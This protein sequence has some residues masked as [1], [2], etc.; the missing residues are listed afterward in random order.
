MIDLLSRQAVEAELVQRWPQRKQDLVSQL[1]ERQHRAAI[2]QR[3]SSFHPADVAFVLESL[4]KDPRDLA[5]SL[6]PQER[7]GA[8]LLETSDAA[9]CEGSSRSGPGTARY[10]APCSDS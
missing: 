3:L 8:V 6:V 7:R 9:C 10:G 5:F 4:E 2:A 1:V